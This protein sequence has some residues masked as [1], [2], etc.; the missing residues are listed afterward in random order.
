MSATPDRFPPLDA[1]RA[2][3]WARFVRPDRTFFPTYVGMVVEEVR[4]GYARIRLPDRPEVSQAAGFIHGGAL[5]TLLDTVAVPAVGTF[6]DA[7][8]EMVT[9]SMTVNFCGSIRG[10]DAVAEGWV[11]QG[12]RSLTF[13][14]AA[15]RGADDGELAA[16]ASLVYRVRPRG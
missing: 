10:Q 4:A 8:P 2:A 7:Q 16:T 15:A 14:R 11:E 6:Y 9:V 12:S 1:E 3:Q 13:V 5:A